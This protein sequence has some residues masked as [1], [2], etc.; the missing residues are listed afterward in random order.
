MPFVDPAGWHRAGLCGELAAGPSSIQTARCGFAQA[1]A[2]EAAAGAF[3][4]Q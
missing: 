1:V 3:P 4:S 2:A